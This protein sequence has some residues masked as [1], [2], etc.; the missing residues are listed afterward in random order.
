MLLGQE[1][2]LQSYILPNAAGMNKGTAG[3]LTAIVKLLCGWRERDR[4]PDVPPMMRDRDA[5]SLGIPPATVFDVLDVISRGRGHQ[6]TNGRRVPVPERQQLIDA[7]RW[8]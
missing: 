3:A 4:Y 1:W 6:Q 8:S 2:R 5:V 7:T